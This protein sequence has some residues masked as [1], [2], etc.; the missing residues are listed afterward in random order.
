MVIEIDEERLKALREWAR[1]EGFGDLNEFASNIV[2]QSVSSKIARPQGRY[3]SDTPI[4][5]LTQDARSEYNLTSG[6]A[7]LGL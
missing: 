4:T 3:V 7:W 1:E 5:M 2:N 6:R